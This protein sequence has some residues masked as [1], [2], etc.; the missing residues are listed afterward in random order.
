MTET[1]ATHAK[2]IRVLP[3]QWRPHYAFEQIAWVSP[4]WPSQEYL[5][6]DFPEGIFT[7]SG[8]LYLSHVNP[9]HPVRFPNLP[10]VEWKTVADGIAFERDL[11]NGVRFGGSVAIN[12]P[13]TVGLELHLENGAA[14][15]LTGIRLQTCAYLRAIRELADFTTT[16]KFVHLPNAG[17]MSFDRA[18][19]SDETGAYR[20]G[21]R[22]QGPARA[23]WPVLVTQSNMAPRFVGMTWY[24]DSISIMANPGHPCMHVDPALPDLAP[25]QR[26]SIRGELL[27][28][29]G[30][31]GEFEDWFHERRQ[32]RQCGRLIRKEPS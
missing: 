27:F 17:W 16:N 25:N 7:D 18:Q 28:Y 30:S 6:L 32:Q 22:G 24:E 3:G 21:F 12:G 14:Q 15:P 29:E 19:Q 11:P 26:H 8:L 20:L 5:W 23:D 2:G 9:Q 10:K 4:P 31:L 13:T 1:Y